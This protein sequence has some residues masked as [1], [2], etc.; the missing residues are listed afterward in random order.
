M[1]YFNNDT[2]AITN[3]NYYKFAK[4]GKLIKSYALFKSPNT[5]AYSCITKNGCYISDNK[6]GY[7]FISNNGEKDFYNSNRGLSTDYV[8]HVYEMKDGT[9]AFSTLG[10]GIQFI[11]NDYRKTYSTGN[12]I[13]RSIVKSGNDWYVL[14]G[15]KVFTIN[16][17]TFSFTAVSSILSVGTITPRS[18]IS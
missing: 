14:A 4:N 8:T 17:T 9:I 12:R 16:Q 2:I 7:Y 6:T 15:E 13:V 10:A 18:I 1:G 11:N 5:Y 3:T